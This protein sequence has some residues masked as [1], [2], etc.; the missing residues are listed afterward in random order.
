MGV[1]GLLTQISSIFCVP[2]HPPCGS[3]VKKLK[4][5]TCSPMSSKGALWFN[6]YRYLLNSVHFLPFSNSSKETVQGRGAWPFSSTGFCVCMCVCV[7]LP[8]S[9]CVCQC[10]SPA[11]RKQPEN[12]S[13]GAKSPFS[14]QLAPCPPLISTHCHTHRHAHTRTHTYM[15]KRAH[16]STECCSIS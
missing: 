7:R 13:D 14:L 12:R 3:W 15:L 9:V 5:P 10:V 8:V 2:P 1:A 6:G 4:V 16:T 11:M